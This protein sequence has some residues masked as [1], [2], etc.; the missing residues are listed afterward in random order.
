MLSTLLFIAAA[1]A[2]PTGW[3]LVSDDGVIEVGRKTVPDSPLFAF[4]GAMVMEVHASRLA[5]VLLTDEIGQEWVDLMVFSKALRDEGDGL[6]LIH[7]NYDL[8]WPL[9]DR[10]Y[11][12]RQQATYDAETGIFTLTFESVEDSL[13][14]ARDCCVRAQAYRTYWRLQALDDGG[15]FVEV[16]VL[17][18]PAG[19]L[20]AWLVNA[21]Q[22]DWPRAT[23]TG[24]KRRATQG[25]LQG[26]DAMVG[27]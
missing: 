19:A 11:L 21:I 27:W 25:D 1:A 23:L 2:L 5:E 9:K 6:R 12:M 7:Q 17:T 15:T 26:L 4:R 16:E 8:P 14:P 24:L 22:K 18:D 10:D 20:P 3:E 13:L